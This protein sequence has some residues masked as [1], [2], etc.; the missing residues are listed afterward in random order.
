MQPILSVRFY[1]TSTGNEPVRD[2]LKDG[3]SI[4]ARKV[5]GADIKTVQFGWPI[6]M[7]VVRKMEPG[8][9]EVRSNIPKGIARILFTVAGSEMV[10]LH[11][12]V[13]KNQSTPKAE[14]EVARTR[15]KEVKR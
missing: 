9:W 5:I 14:M 3:V 13:K 8:L 4:T 1:R 15:M 10:L 6:G 2:W 12:F 7:P 11:G